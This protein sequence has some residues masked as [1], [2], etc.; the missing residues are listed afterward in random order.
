MGK[1]QTFDDHYDMIK[2]LYIIENKRLP[3]VI[4]IMKRKGFIKSKSSYERWLKRSDIK[5]NV[6]NWNSLAP[7]ICE[8]E[9]KG[10]ETMIALNAFRHRDQ[11]WVRKNKS[12]HP[13]STADRLRR[14]LSLQKACAQAGNAPVVR[15]PNAELPRIAIRSPSPMSPTL[16]VT[17]VQ[18]ETTSLWFLFEDMLRGLG[19]P[20]KA[21]SVGMSISQLPAI[22]TSGSSLDRFN[23][24]QA[25]SFSPHREPQPEGN[26]YPEQ[27]LCNPLL[28]S[29]T[30]M[31]LRSIMPG[32]YASEHI[33]IGEVL[34][35]PLLIA[36]TE[37]VLRSIM[38]ERYP[39]EHKHMAE[40]LC[41]RSGAKSPEYF[42]LQLYRLAN[43]F[44]MEDQNVL[45]LVRNLGSMWKIGLRELLSAKD[46]VMQAI[47]EKAF[48][49]AVRS[50]NADILE[51]LVGSG[52]N[53]NTIL[54]GSGADCR[55]FYQT[56]ISVA[57]RR[58]NAETS[59][60]MVQLLIKHHGGVVSGAESLALENA[61]LEGREAVVMAL[62]N[63]GVPLDMT[64]LLQRLNSEFYSFFKSSEYPPLKTRYYCEGEKAV[65]MLKI[66]AAAGAS[67]LDLRLAMI[68]VVNQ[69]S[70]ETVR[71]L[72]KAIQ[73]RAE[74]EGRGIDRYVDLTAGQFVSILRTAS[75]DG[76][77]AI[78]LGA[79]CEEDEDMVRLLIDSRHELI[80]CLF[81]DTWIPS[82]CKCPQSHHLP[83]DLEPSCPRHDR[84]SWDELKSSTPLGLATVFG[85]TEIAKF[86]IAQGADV[87]ALSQTLFFRG[88]AKM[89]T[90]QG[91][92][93]SRGHLAMVNLLI[94]NGAK[95]SNAFPLLVACSQ[96]Y[97]ECALALLTAGMNVI[98][99][100]SC[101]K[102]FSH[103][104][105]YSHCSS[106]S[107]NMSEL[108]ATAVRRAVRVGPVNIVELLLDAGFIDT[109]K[110]DG[111]CDLEMAIFLEQSGLLGGIIQ[112]NGANILASAIDGFSWDLA[113]Y[114]AS[115]HN[116]D[117][118]A[119]RDGFSD[120][121]NKAVL[122]S[123]L[124]L[125]PS[126]L[127]QKAVIAASTWGCIFGRS[128]SWGNHWLL[129]EMLSILLSHLQVSHGT[130]HVR[131]EMAEYEDRWIPAEYGQPKGGVLLQ[132]AIA[133]SLECVQML[134]H[135]GGWDPEHLGIALTAAA[136]HEHDH[137]A[138]FLLDR[139]APLE[140]PM[141]ESSLHR[142]RSLI[143]SPLVAAAIN[144]NIDQVQN[145]INLGAR[146]DGSAGYE[147]LCGAQLHQGG[148]NL[149]ELIDILLEAGAHPGDGD[150]SWRVQLPSPLQI[151]AH[152][153]NYRVACRLIEY[154]ANVNRAPFTD[155]YG[156]T[157]EGSS[158]TALQFAA[159]Q[160]NLQMATLF[161]D[162]GADTDAPAA[163]YH[164]RTVLEG[165]AEKGRLEMI[166]FLFTR[167]PKPSVDGE[168]RIQFLRAVKLA[169]NHGHIAIV[170]LLKAYGGWS[171]S[172]D[173]ESSE[174][175]KVCRAGSW[176]EEWTG[177]GDEEESDS[178]FTDEGDTDEVMEFSYTDQAS[179]TEA[180]GGS[181]EVSA[182]IFSGACYPSSTDPE[183][184]CGELFTHWSAEGGEASDRSFASPGFWDDGSMLGGGSW[185]VDSTNPVDGGLGGIIP[186]AD[187]N[188]DFDEIIRDLEAAPSE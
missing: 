32:I 181:M 155:C 36:R 5:K 187:D 77:G 2:Q 73:S 63:V 58:M 98:E 178:D 4:E 183:L 186:D 168:H 34:C 88:G 175:R 137:I 120:S 69:G 70:V 96:G 162:N 93:A 1:Q 56:A 28:I 7:V 19:I 130:G 113:R 40:V 146:V 78:L 11:K 118:S 71:A 62:I 60:R 90:P 141:R 45:D 148:P 61:L 30:E 108:G 94:E 92:A 12:R 145:L 153:E 127:D 13:V 159:I 97:A 54:S 140:E 129:E 103:F 21:V 173:R 167:D 64:S 67:S 119:D 158:A 121:L 39:S 134:M 184:M 111:I 144:G 66:L 29:Q 107:C 125:V 38:P 154:G 24:Y 59:L 157:T 42:M 126:L 74:E 124:D 55:P 115:S 176:E 16:R 91:L 80:N 43:N 52:L 161:L 163:N 87:N 47:K 35:T 149:V 102:T 95:L 79:I 26:S 101:A 6:T 138:H 8:R 76:C 105:C 150:F 170:E 31:A 25:P 81:R 151:A 110:V 27:E 85:N 20:T 169:E 166:H 104:A 160:G 41:T 84:E 65:S 48:S 182:T 72:W 188:F 49:I 165:A 139:G 180:E 53:S 174:N 114:L 17:H 117:L 177:P 51:M 164:G 10:K 132:A 147:A 18:R 152:T 99:G 156:M 57:M 86:L 15:L 23:L 3:E 75:V 142:S 68:A 172:D 122:Q 82:I 83:R 89:M 171:E 112:N 46:C 109:R 123:Q 131:P 14:E 106:S 33:H 37:M 50:G 100:D 22:T 9:Q 128:Y 136:Y 44:P 185:D 133:G 116:I 179:L 143:S 135:A